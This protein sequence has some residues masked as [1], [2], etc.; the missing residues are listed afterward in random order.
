M[1]IQAPLQ[2]LTTRTAQPN[3][4]DSVFMMGFDAWS[5][6]KL[7]KQ[8]LAGCHS[9]PKYRK[10]K[11]YVLTDSEGSLISSLITYRL[12]VHVAGI[13][14]IATP[15]ALRN[16][17]YASRLISGVISILEVRERVQDIF[18]FADIAPRF[19]KPFGFVPLPKRHQRYPDS[20]CMIRSSSIERIRD[21]YFRPPA[22]F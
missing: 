2:K 13:G 9:S 3:E 10:G 16:H 5:G 6:G 22:Y 12:S 11:W 15:P 1:S 19:Y 20:V 17:G 7:K 21:P 18:L 8:Y 14:S 4:L